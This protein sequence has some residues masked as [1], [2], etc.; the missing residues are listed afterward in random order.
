MRRSRL[1]KHLAL[2][3]VTVAAATLCLSLVGTSVPASAGISLAPFESI[4]ADVTP[5]QTITR[6]ISLSI[7]KQDRA[8]DMAV[9]VTGFGS[10]P[11]GSVLRVENANDTGPYSARTFVSIDKRS[12]HLEP[13]GSQDIVATIVV[14]N[15]VGDG[16]RYAIIYIHEQSP[17][18]GAAAG[19][20]SAFN[21]PVLLTIKGST[22]SLLGE[23]T[24]LAAGKAVSGQPIEVF[25]TFRN[26]GNTHFKVTGEVTVSNDR[27]EVLDI[28]TVP[29]SVSSVIPTASRRIRAVFIP[30]GELPMGIYLLRSRLILEEGALLAE[31]NGEFELSAVY[32][33]PAQPTMATP[34][35]VTTATGLPVS[36]GVAAPS[37]SIAANDAGANLIPIVGMGV[38][39]VLLGLGM[40]LFGVKRGRGR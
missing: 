37:P 27:G 2:F 20:L 34:P 13:G 4:R 8:T 6:R 1:D 18:G 24:E 39:A 16:G 26:T 25:V 7:G 15:G 23:I 32:V 30:K 28:V 21:I 38:A 31:A 12:F 10:S 19:S 5:G 35:P 3:R 36:S 29:L 9:D 14:P 11:D 17:A 22:I 40:Y 33:P